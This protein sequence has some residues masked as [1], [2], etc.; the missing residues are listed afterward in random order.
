[1]SHPL[2]PVANVAP[3]RS[4]DEADSPVPA[5]SQTLRDRAEATNVDPGVRAS[6]GWPFIWRERMAFADSSSEPVVRAGRC[7]A[8]DLS[9]AGAAK[10]CR[11]LGSTAC[12]FES[13]SWPTL[14][15]VVIMAS[16]IG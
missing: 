1:Q 6:S 7:A 16:H 3:F 2:Y 10:N 12:R 11:L 15:L 5:A 14:R 4:V 13:G 9:G 8:A